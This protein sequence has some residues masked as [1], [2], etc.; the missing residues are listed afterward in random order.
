MFRTDA[1]CKTKATG[2]DAIIWLLIIRVCVAQGLPI[3]AWME[4]GEH[5]EH[6][7]HHFCMIT[8]VEH[9]VPQFWPN[10]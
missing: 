10:R 2:C 6:E 8:P 7:V 3:R 1:S 4:T 9:A 5:L